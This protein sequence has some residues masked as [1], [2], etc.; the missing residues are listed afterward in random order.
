MN[1]ISLNIVGLARSKCLHKGLSNIL[2]KLIQIKAA[3]LKKNI[4]KQI[5]FPQDLHL[6]G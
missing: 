3:S 2:F 5:K 1:Q 4:K 6:F